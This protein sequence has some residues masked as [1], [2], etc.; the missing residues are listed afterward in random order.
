MN[1]FIK[2]TCFFGNINQ[3]GIQDDDSE[4]EISGEALK[5]AEAKSNVVSIDDIAKDQEI[6]GYDED[7]IYELGQIFACYLRCYKLIGKQQEIYREIQVSIC[8]PLIDKYLKETLN[9]RQQ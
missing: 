8:M 5:R 3:D 2:R 9:M 7:E 1:A 4:E 6:A